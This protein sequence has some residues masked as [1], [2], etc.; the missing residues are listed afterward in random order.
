MQC[1]TEG[2]STQ[3]SDSSSSGL[4]QCTGRYPPWACALLAAVAVSHQANLR[5][6]LLQN[7]HL[8][9]AC[10]PGVWAR[11]CAAEL[12]PTAS[13]GRPRRSPLPHDPGAGPVSAVLV[14]RM[15]A[16]ES[17]AAAEST[18][19]AEQVGSHQSQNWCHCPDFHPP[20]SARRASSE[21][22]PN[23]PA[24]P[25]SKVRAPLHQWHVVCACVKL[26]TF[27]ICMA[28]KLQTAVHRQFGSSG[29]AVCT[30]PCCS[31]FALARSMCH[32]VPCSAAEVQDHW[33]GAMSLCLAAGP[34]HSDP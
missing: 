6:A 32:P 20:H 4:P 29:S 14:L 1:S 11:N 12:N 13:V 7:Q 26:Q 2:N 5:S 21:V 10:H 27:C 15:S 30:F 19:P 25:Q 3:C 22:H 23:D 8:Q 17:T 33:W 31:S 34:L 24:S 16:A 9:M 18:S 28:Y